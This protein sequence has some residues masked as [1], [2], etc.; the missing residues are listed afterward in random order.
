M[1]LRIL[2]TLPALALLSMGSLAQDEKKGDKK[3]A[4]KKNIVAIDRKEAGVDYLVQGEYQGD[5]LAA[6]VFAAGDGKFDVYLLTGGLPG[7]GW[8]GKGR[9][10]VA[11]VLDAEQASALIKGP[12]ITGVIKLGEPAVLTGESE[13]DGKFT[14]TRVERKSPTLGAKPPEGARVLF[15]G[16]D[17][18]EWGSAKIQNDLLAIPATTKKPYKIAKLH[19]EFMTPFMPSARGQGRGNSGVYIYGKEIQVLDSFALDGKN[20]ECGGIYSEAAPKV[21]MCLPPLSW[22][23]YDIEFM[24][25]EPDPKTKK[26][27]NL[28]TVFHNG[29]KIHENYPWN[30]SGNINLQ[31]HGNPVFFKNIWLIEA[32]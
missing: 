14:L 9:V 13:K 4:P 22:Q 3:P 10:K 29:V 26:A 8:D 28:I 25:A 19:I 17:N 1:T 23:T 11:A 20:N 2:L 24:P 6:Q 32:K 31:N 27:T 18:G 21:N 16:K 30:A 7:A 12:A 5:K 15:D